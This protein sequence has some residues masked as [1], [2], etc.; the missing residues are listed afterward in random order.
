LKCFRR[1]GNPFPFELAGVFSKLEIRF[2]NHKRVS[3]AR[4][5]SVDIL[6]GRKL[7][8]GVV[9]LNQGKYPVDGTLWLARTGAMQL[10]NGHG[11]SAKMRES[12]HSHFP[13][14]SFFLNTTI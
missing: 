8:S 11:Q 7:K 12:H 13:S 6:A 5:I 1:T 4:N 14:I 2:N 9:E 10:T 3:S